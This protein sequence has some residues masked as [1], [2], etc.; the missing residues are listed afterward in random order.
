MTKPTVCIVESLRLLEESSHR[1][2]EIIFR[3]LRLSEKQADYIY[4][5]S[6]RELETVA[7]EF[8]RS[9]HRYLHSACNGNKNTFST[10]PD[11]IKSSDF[12][13][14]LIPHP[15]DR[16]VFLSSCFAGSSVFAKKLLDQ[17][18]CFSVLCPV[19]N[20][21]FDDAA[22]FWTSFYHLM[23]KRNP[24]SMNSTASIENVVKC[25]NLVGEEFTFFYR[26][27][28]RV[29]EKRIR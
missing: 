8:G 13:N 5:R 14:I 21:R 11:R 6:R 24:G 16:R 9:D 7:D 27:A 25:A 29:F 12:A 15:D 10:T 19:E 26:K 20:I 3:T 23:F 2:G 28:G 22:I 1:E 18:K 17:S 4:I